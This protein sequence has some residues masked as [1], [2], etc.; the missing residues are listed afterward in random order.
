MLTRKMCVVNI[1]MSPAVVSR[2]GC[3]LMQHRQAKLSVQPP[4]IVWSVT[5]AS[6]TFQMCSN[7][8][9]AAFEEEKKGGM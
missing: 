4:T 8:T 3:Y 6:R 9:G 5:P 2:N 1:I 7:F